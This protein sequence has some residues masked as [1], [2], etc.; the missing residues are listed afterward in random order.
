VTANCGPWV[1]VDWQ[2]LEKPQPTDSIEIIYVAAPL[3]ECSYGNDFSPLGAYHGGVAFRNQRTEFTFTLNYDAYPS[4]TG[5]LIPTIVKANGTTELQWENTG[6]VFVYIGLNETYWERVLNVGTM[7]GA[8]LLSFY[9]WV[10][11][12]NQTYQYYN[13]WTVYSSWPGK[14]LLPPFECFAYVWDAFAEIESLGGHFYSVQP[15]M[16]LITLYSSM[17]PQLVNTNDTN[18]WAK[19]VDFYETLEGKYKQEGPLLFFMEI[20]DILVDGYFYVRSDADYY[21]IELHGEPPFAIHF[22]QVPI[23][24]S[25]GASGL[26]ETLATH[27]GAF[28]GEGETKHKALPTVHTNEELRKP[29]S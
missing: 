13:L 8:Q 27:V 11:T 4:F 17:T 2:T 7:T 16:S 10:G 28:K 25:K 29:R 22:L 18:E 20:F 19:V 1:A 5:A 3:L 14:L 24:A 21:F 26:A 23:D 6:R 15:Y 12:N 9:N